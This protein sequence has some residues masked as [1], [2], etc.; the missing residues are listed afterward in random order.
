[1]K[2]IALLALGLVLVLLSIVMLNTSWADK[3]KDSPL[4]HVVLFKFKPEATQ[5]QIQE[6]IQEFQKLPPQIHE[7]RDFEWG[8]D[9][10]PEQLSKGL[11]HCFLVTFAST[12]D[13]DAYLVHPLHLAFVQKL[14]PLLDDATV[15]D[16]WAQ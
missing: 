16:Y 8:T 1:M 15:V 10:S 14:K 5:E 11:T 3:K 9:N 4:R 12:A 6:L 13:R 2:T 7:I